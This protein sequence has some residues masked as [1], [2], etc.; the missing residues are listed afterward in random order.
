MN[1]GTG[2]VLRGWGLIARSAFLGGLV[3]SLV[4]LARCRATATQRPGRRAN[5]FHAGSPRLACYAQGTSIGKGAWAKCRNG[6]CR[7]NC[8]PLQA[9]NRL[10]ASCVL[11]SSGGVRAAELRVGCM[12]DGPDRSTWGIGVGLTPARQSQACFSACWVPA[13]MG[14]GATTDA[15]WG[16][17]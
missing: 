17:S 12:G 3:A 14:P 13:G 15:R 2:G 11:F 9:R 10:L 16:S 7:D 5:W 6:R 8:T 4:G 1:V